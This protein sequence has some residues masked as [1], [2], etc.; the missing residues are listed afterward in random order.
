[1][2]TQPLCAS[3]LNDR[4]LTL[5][6]GDHLNNYRFAKGLIDFINQAATPITIA[7]QGGWGSGKTS[8]I[9]LLG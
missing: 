1:M 7:I 4:P 3:C 2:S 8:L 6:E 9:N 5:R